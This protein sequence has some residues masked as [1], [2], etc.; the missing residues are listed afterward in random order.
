MPRKTMPLRNDLLN[1]ISADSPTGKYLR[2]DPLYDKIREARREDKA[3]PQGD[4]SIERKVADWP[5]T[6]ALT[7]DALATKTKDLQL[8]AWLAQALLRYEG[9]ASFREGL[10]L[11]SKLLEMYWEGIYPQPEDGDLEPR[12][13]PLEWLATESDREPNRPVT[14]IKF[15]PLTSGGLTFVQFMETREVGTEEAV[16]DSY[17]RQQA[18]AK[19]IE[20][21][22]TPP[23]VFEKA[24]AATDKAFYAELEQTFD[25]TLESL[26]HLSQLCDEKFGEVSPSFSEL[27]TVVEE[28]RQ[29]V[30]TLLLRKREKEPDEAATTDEVPAPGG[31]EAPAG[32]LP[33]GRG[34]VVPMVGSA[35]ATG[36]AARTAFVPA[37][38]APLPGSWE[39]AIARVVAAAKFMRQQDP[40]NPAPYAMLRGLWWGEL[41]ASGTGIDPAKLVAPPSEVRQGL[42]RAALDSNWAE[43]LETAETAMGM[44]CGRGWLDLQCYVVRACQEL[45]GYYERVRR[46]VVAELGTLLKSCPQLP[47][48]TMMDDMATANADTLAWI[49]RQVLPHR[50]P[51]GRESE[52]IAPSAGTGSVISSRAFEL[53][54]QA[55]RSGRPE[56]SIELLTREIAQ[57]ASGRGR[58]L[59]KVQLARL[60]EAAGNDKIALSMLQQTVAEIEEKKLEEWESREMLA[61]PL[62]LLYRCLVKSDGSSEDRD[63]VYAW[64][65]RLDPLEAMKLER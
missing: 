2:H 15:V 22:K 40:Y 47:G 9:V 33:E 3:G 49:Q 12:V 51:E 8:A 29:V 46:T 52:E 25:G 18:R 38:L 24:F 50:A 23:E 5:L 31:E 37:A 32:P 42:K 16:A 61:Y 6:I 65:C 44:E 4:W 35:P 48:M 41:R 57:E 30:H 63:R 20:E 28:V 10:D 17:E 59:R 64:I 27:Q 53:A 58:F 1:P 13:G 39:D 54:M 11:I 21:G 7:S 55:A 34:P 26:R 56:V 14:T 60:S 62:V 36:T 19:K 45:G 43:V